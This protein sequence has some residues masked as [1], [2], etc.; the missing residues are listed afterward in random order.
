MEVALSTFVQGKMIVAKY[1]AGFNDL[2]RFAP[3]VASN[4]L[5][6]AK[7]YRRRL[8]S[9][10]RHVMRATAPRDFRSVVEQSRGMEILCTNAS[11]FRLVCSESARYRVQYD[12]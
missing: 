7:R 11:Y 1:E 4:D 8:N 10:F 9:E 3:S 12:V 2:I 6:K 5:E